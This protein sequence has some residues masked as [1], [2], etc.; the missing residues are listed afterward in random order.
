MD[1]EAATV[2]HDRATYLSDVE[3]GAHSNTAASYSSAAL[4]DLKLEANSAKPYVVHS[5][6][7]TQTVSVGTQTQTELPPGSLHSVRRYVEECS[8]S[9]L[10]CYTTRL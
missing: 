7:V 9:L 6:S 5:V 4:Y 10:I 2:A 3:Q 1:V 8:G